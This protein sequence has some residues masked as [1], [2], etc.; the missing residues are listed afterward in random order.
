M[1][2]ALLVIEAV[3]QDHLQFAAIL[4]EIASEKIAR[5]L[6]LVH[7]SPRLLRDDSSRIGD[8]DCTDVRSTP[9]S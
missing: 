9:Y 3:F 4:W 2:E 8:R 6:A 5:T 1:R 7:R